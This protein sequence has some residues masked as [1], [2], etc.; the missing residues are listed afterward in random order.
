MTI[1]VP[2]EGLE[3]SR[4]STPGFESGVS[5]IPPF[6]HV[7]AM[8]GF[9]PTETFVLSKL[10]LPICISHIA[11]YY[12]PYFFCRYNRTFGLYLINSLFWYVIVSIFPTM[13]PTSFDVKVFSH[14]M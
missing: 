3:P 11:I 12:L 14:F 9:E 5:T 2:E 10:T 8:V 13:E 1:L 4:L 6:R 7:V